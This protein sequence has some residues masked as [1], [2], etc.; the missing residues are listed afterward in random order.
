M[1]FERVNHPVEVIKIALIIISDSLLNL[2]KN[3]VALKKA[4]EKNKFELFSY[5]PCQES[6]RE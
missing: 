6:S 4:V 2:L 5:C 3:L 1:F